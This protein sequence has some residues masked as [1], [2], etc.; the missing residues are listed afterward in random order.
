MHSKLGLPAGSRRSCKAQLPISISPSSKISRRSLTRGYSGTRAGPFI[1]P[2]PGAIARAMKALLR[3]L[4]LLARRDE[5]ILSGR[6]AA[7]V[8]KD[9]IPRDWPRHSRK[10]PRAGEVAGG[11]G[12]QAIFAHSVSFPAAL[13]RHICF[14]EN[15][16]LRRA[17]LSSIL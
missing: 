12:R 13:H 3:K 6:P 9:R 7:E 2:I 16:D 15:V 1:I 5:A 10:I 4:Q 11:A 8:D 14:W 17:R